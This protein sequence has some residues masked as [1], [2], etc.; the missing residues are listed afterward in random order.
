MKRRE[1]TLTFELLQ[2]YKM[3]K[4]VNI[5]ILLLIIQINNDKNKKKYKN[6]DDTT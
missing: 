3:S 5:I 1:D 4:R 2:N 6:S